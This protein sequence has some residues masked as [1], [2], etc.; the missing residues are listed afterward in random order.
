MLKAETT[1]L[2]TS[3]NPS[4]VVICIMLCHPI[5]QH[6]SN[7]EYYIDI[8]ADTNAL[9]NTVYMPPQ[10]PIASFVSSVLTVH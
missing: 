6:N 9:N 4:D 7:N 10:K 3:S 8:R 2:P 5:T 1:G